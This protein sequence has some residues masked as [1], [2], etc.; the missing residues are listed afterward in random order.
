MALVG[1]DF[2]EELDGRIAR[3]PQNNVLRSGEMFEYDRE[4]IE[5]GDYKG[6]LKLIK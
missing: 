5:R 2:D 1:G 4:E 3:G 6:S